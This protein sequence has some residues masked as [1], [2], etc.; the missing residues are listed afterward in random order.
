MPANAGVDDRSPGLFYLF[1]QHDDFL[2]GAAAFDEVEHGKSKNDNE[3]FP[4]PPAD[5]LDNLNG[6]ATSVAEWPA[7]LIITPIGLLGHELIDQVALRA[8]DLHAVIA[9][10]VGELGTPGEIVDG[11]FH[12]SV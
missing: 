4:D 8:H 7:P 11:G 5:R 2:P 3:I 12:S 10:Q 6:E 1:G 9:G